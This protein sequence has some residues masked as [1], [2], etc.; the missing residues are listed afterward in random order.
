MPFP[1]FR[2]VSTLPSSGSRNDEVDIILIFIF[3]E[4]ISSYQNPPIKIPQKKK[5]IKNS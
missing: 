2:L 3:E 1:T 4:D 5:K